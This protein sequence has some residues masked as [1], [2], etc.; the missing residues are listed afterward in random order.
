MRLQLALGSRGDAGVVR[1]GATRAEISAEFDA[2]AALRAWLDE[3]G[4]DAGDT[5]LLRRTIDHQ[6]KSRAWINGSSATI[7]QLREAADHLVEIHGQHAWQSL[8]KPAAVRALLDTHAGIDPAPAAAAWAAWRA[9]LARWSTRA[10][11]ATA[12]N[13]NASACSGR[14]ASWTSSPRARRSGPS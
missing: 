10:A 6:G 14:S 12:W 9:A 8:T 7:G 4:F 1:E 5:L 2:P 13:V 11:S 3:A